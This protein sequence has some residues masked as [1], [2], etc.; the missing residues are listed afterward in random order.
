MKLIKF[1]VIASIAVIC[2]SVLFMIALIPLN[3]KTSQNMNGVDN[4]SLIIDYRD[5]TQKVKKDFSLPTGETT[6]F[7]ALNK[8]CDVKYKDYGVQGYFVTSIDGKSGDWI[9]FV[10]NESPNV[11]SIKF[12]LNDGDVIKWVRI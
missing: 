12:Y 7:D 9:Y 2:F 4:I 5:G 6:A 10:N 8:W 3:Q 1:I 11:S